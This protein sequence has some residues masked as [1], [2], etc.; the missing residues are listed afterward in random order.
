MAAEVFKWVPDRNITGTEKDRVR[1]ARFGDG[2]SQAVGD[3]INTREGSWPLTFTGQKARI[4]AIKAFLD[5]HAGYKSFLWAPPL[6]D[7]A[8]FRAPERS[9]VAR[10]GNV[11]QLT[12]TFNQVYAP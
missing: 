3:G 7:P 8:L 4:S 1:T 6:S 12:V 10:G 5:R 11:F 9:L 2:Y